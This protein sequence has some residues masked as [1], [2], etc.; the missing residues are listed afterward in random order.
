MPTIDLVTEIRAPISRVFDLARCVDLHVESTSATREQAVAG[1]VTGLIGLGQDVTWR[2]RHFGVWQE[3]T[4]RI[5]AYERPYQFRDSMVR[6]AFRRLDHDH[7]FEE[8]D[9]I[10]SMRDRFDFES[11]LGIFGIVAD[12]LFLRRYLEGFLIHRNQLI[13]AV[14]ESERWQ[15]FLSA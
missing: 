15:K 4:G 7:L 13:K 6:G 10:T 9:G 3:L 1:F 12:Q 14:A 5:T 8:D 2:A 11:P